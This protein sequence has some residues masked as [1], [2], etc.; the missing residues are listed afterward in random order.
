MKTQFTSNEYGVTA[1]QLA[2]NFNGDIEN[3]ETL[4][5]WSIS[6]AP[7]GRGHYK[8]TIE[9]NINGEELIIKTSTSNMN[10]IDAW[11]SGD[12]YEDGEDMFENW[13]EVVDSM[14]NVIDIEEQIEE[15]LF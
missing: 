14:L 3:V 13:N 2:N 6:L 11:T 15:F 10:L 5:L 8:L 9:L 12:N 7:S 4:N 1:E